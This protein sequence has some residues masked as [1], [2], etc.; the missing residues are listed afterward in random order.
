[1]PVSGA[2]GRRLSLI[3]RPLCR[4]TPAQEIGLPAEL[5]LIWTALGDLYLKEGE[6][7]QAHSAFSKAAL[8]VHKLAAGIKDDVRR[9]IYLSS[10]LVQ[11]VLGAVG[12]PEG[13]YAFK[14]EY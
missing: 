6:Q 14:Q 10:P 2:A 3:L 5:L 12:G 11:Q 13:R 7:E 9:K 1:M 8:F 4:P